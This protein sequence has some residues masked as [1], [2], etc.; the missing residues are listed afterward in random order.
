M[1]DTGE[2]QRTTMR[3][4]VNGTYMVEEMT[5]SRVRAIVGVRVKHSNIV[6]E[7]TGE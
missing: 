7:M 4:R 5:G 1:K 3:V 6:K 2:E